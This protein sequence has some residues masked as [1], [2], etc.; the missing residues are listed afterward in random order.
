MSLF[1]I[2]ACTMAAHDE[3]RCAR[4]ACLSARWKCSPL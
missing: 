4:D 1:E 2:E 3:R